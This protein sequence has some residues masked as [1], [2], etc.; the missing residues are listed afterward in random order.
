MIAIKNEIEYN[1]IMQ[2]I[3]EL[4]A[5]IDDATPLKDKN[6]IELDLLSGLV[7]DYEDIH[8]PI[9][10]PTLASVLKLRMYELGLTQKQLSELLHVSQSRI[11]DYLTGRSE[12]TLKIARE[13]SVKL[14][15]DSSIVLGV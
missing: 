4:M 8:Y 15:I 6:L 3:E 11:S 2:R 5:L 9:G 12:P 14:H 13:M 1:A 7:E 10:N